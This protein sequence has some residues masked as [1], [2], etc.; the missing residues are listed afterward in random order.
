MKNIFYKFLF[1]FLKIGKQIFILY[2]FFLKIGKQIFIHYF[3]YWIFGKQIFILYF[4]F[5]KLVNRLFYTLF[6]W[7][8]DNS[9]NHF[10]YTLSDLI[11]L[12]YIKWTIFHLCIIQYLYYLATKSW[13]HITLQLYKQSSLENKHIQS[14]ITKTWNV[15][16]EHGWCY[17]MT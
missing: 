1:L 16:E 12:Q 5:W 17:K 14:I 2:F 15:L 6:L 11:I 3:F 4:L 8:F 7:K 13:K 9:L 10:K